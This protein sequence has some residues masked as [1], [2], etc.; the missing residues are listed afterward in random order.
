MKSYIVDSLNHKDI[1]SV[2]EV[3]IKRFG[4]PFM[5]EIFHAVLDSSVLSSE[6]KKH[7][8]CSP[9]YF[10]LCL[11]K[12]KLTAETLVRS[13]KKMRCSCMGYADSKQILWLIDLINDILDESGIRI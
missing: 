11:E 10:A 8:E 3:L 13:K 4:T 5:D 6:Q 7:V 9:H 12:D 2:K 1:S